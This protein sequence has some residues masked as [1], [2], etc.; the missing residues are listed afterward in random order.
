MRMKTIIS[1]VTLFILG[2]AVFFLPIRESD[3]LR[4]RYILGLWFFAEAAYMMVPGDRIAT[5]LYQLVG[6]FHSWRD[7]VVAAVALGAY[8]V[9]LFFAVYLMMNLVF[10]LE[11]KV[12]LAIGIVLIT[13]LVYYGICFL[14]GSDELRVAVIPRFV[15][16]GIGQDRE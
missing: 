12:A 1:F 13:W 11:V 5:P 9:L 3:T 10:I 14:F 6:R 7:R 8:F 15:R 16:R 4:L 2:A